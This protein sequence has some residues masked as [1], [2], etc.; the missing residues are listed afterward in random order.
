MIISARLITKFLS[1]KRELF[2]VNFPWVVNIDTERKFFLIASSPN[3]QA[4]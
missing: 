3:T 4:T 1:G 2:L